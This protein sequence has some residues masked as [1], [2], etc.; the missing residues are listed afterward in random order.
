MYTR[1]AMVAVVVFDVNDPLS[2]E[3]AVTQLKEN[4]HLPILALVANKVDMLQDPEN[5]ALILE[6]KKQADDLNA[7][8]FLTSAK[9]GV[10]VAKMFDVLGTSSRGTFRATFNK[11]I[12]RSLTWE[13]CLL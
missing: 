10:G 8:F 13:H 12:G 2:L 9:T 11:T 1:D 4:K 7:N 5:D 3:S 6:A